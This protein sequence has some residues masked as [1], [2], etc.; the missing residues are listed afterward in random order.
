MQGSGGALLAASLDGG[1][2]S[3]FA[4]GENANRVLLSN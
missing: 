2:T 4:A 3:I 1:D